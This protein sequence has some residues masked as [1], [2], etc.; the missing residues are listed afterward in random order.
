M[1]PCRNQHTAVHVLVNGQ[2]IT[3]VTKLV[4]LYHVYSGGFRKLR[5]Y[6]PPPCNFK[7][8]KRFHVLT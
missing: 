5:E 4:N 6:N 7:E 2:N 8:H 3:F 1:H